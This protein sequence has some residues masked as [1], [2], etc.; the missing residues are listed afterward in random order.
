MFTIYID[1][2]S[3]YMIDVYGLARWKRAT[4]TYL[5]KHRIPIWFHGRRT[6]T[7]GCSLQWNYTVNTCSTLKTVRLNQNIIKW[8]YCPK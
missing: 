7:I 4:G 8:Q 3:E 1:S 5:Q 6:T 2:I